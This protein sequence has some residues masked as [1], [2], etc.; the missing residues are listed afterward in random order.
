MELVEDG[1]DHLPGIGGLVG[2]ACYTDCAIYQSLQVDALLSYIAE[3]LTKSISK[4]LSLEAAHIESPETRQ[5]VIK[6]DV[7]LIKHL[8]HDA[9]D[10]RS[11]VKECLP[12]V[13]VGALHSDVLGEDALGGLLALG[14]HH[15]VP[16]VQPLLFRQHQPLVELGRIV[17]IGDVSSVA[18][19]LL[20]KTHQRR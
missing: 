7:T 6:G 14:A 1:F 15:R 19:S 11:S 20:M 8:F 4:R 18:Q 10:L 16:P 3:D 17:A 9:W 12:S 5:H 2:A 13:E